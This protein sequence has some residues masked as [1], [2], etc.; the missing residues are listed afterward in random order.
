MGA[1]V[2][3]LGDDFVDGVVIIIDR[4]DNFVDG[5]VIII[6]RVDNVVDLAADAACPAGGTPA[7][8]SPTLP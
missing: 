6:D 2:I 3:D 1:I 8:R 7:L 4:G 5:V